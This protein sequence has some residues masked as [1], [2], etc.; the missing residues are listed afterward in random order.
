[1]FANVTGNSVGMGMASALDTLVSQSYGA[2]QYTLVGLHTQRGMFVLTLLCVPVA[3][4]WLF[5]EQFLLALQMP[6][7]VSANAG[8]W[9][10]LLII[11]LWPYLMFEC[12][13]RYLQGQRV[14]W[15]IVVASTVA[16]VINVV[17]NVIFV[18]VLDFQMMGSALATALSNWVSFIT[19]T[20]CIVGRSK[21]RQRQRRR[22]R[23]ISRE[24][25]MIAPNAGEPLR[26]S[27]FRHTQ[28]TN[29]TL[30]TATHSRDGSDLTNGHQRY[31]PSESEMTQNSS[32][33]TPGVRH[34]V[35]QLPHLQTNAPVGISQLGG[36][37]DTWPEVN[38]KEILYWTA[39][40]DWLRLGVPGAAS[41]FVEQSSY[42][43]AAFL[44]GLLGK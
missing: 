4:V 39:L 19:L 22:A 27:S 18:V 41:Q 11:G 24:N 32:T 34:R 33:M 30:S 44:A 23:A 16:A 13:R 37:D 7:D 35:L 42:E 3:V 40:S 12:L 17:F 8:I 43:A 28:H 21:Y 6:H 14:L 10:R 26:Q 9:T 38:I 5:T 29:S 25:A 20:I 31:Y 15:P 1:M 2:K 36:P